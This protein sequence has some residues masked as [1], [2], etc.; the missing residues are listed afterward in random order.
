MSR[1][2][3]RPAANA[4]RILLIEDSASARR[5][6]QDL[7]LRLGAEIPNLRAAGTVEEALALFDEWHPDLAFIDVELPAPSPEPSGRAASGRPHDGVELARQLLARDPEL[8][9]ILS[10]AFDPSEA[11]IAAL[12]AEFPIEVIVKPLLAARLDDVLARTLVGPGVGE[13]VREPERRS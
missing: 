2:D 3:A 5:L 13:R 10:T 8:R 12:R 7:L 9:V 11:R 6:L 1:R 4:G